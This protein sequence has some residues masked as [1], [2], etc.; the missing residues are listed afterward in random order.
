MVRF[1]GNLESLI[2]VVQVIGASTTFL[3]ALLFIWLCSVPRISPG[4]RW[5]TVGLIVS[6]LGFSIFTLP[7][8][9]I[10][11]ID[12]SGHL[13]F[14]TESL[15]AVC[16][17]IGTRQ[18]AGL[19]VHKSFYMYAL[20]ATMITALAFDFVFA[21]FLGYFAVIS[22]FNGA[23]IMATGYCIFKLH[24]EQWGYA[25][26]AIGILFIIWG[27]HW[28][29]A[30]VLMQ[31]EALFDYGFLFALLISNL[32]I[33]GY[34]AL[35]LHSLVERI[36]SAERV[37]IELSLKDGLTT[38]WNRRYLDNVFTNFSTNAERHHHKMALIYIDLDHFKPV[39]D[40]YGHDVGDEVLRQV[41]KR[42]MEISRSSDVAIRTGG[43]EFV[44]LIP[45]LDE[46]E[47]VMPQAARLRE[48]ITMPYHINGDTVTVG[49]S[50]GVSIF[51]DH[52]MELDPLLEKADKA[53]YHAKN[54][55]RNGEVMFDKTANT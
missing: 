8:I 10:G 25:Y 41:A 55:G 19:A 27:I 36:I 32:A 13:Y 30:P 24:K 40:T 18:F 47:N 12:L 4:I 1:G 48:R 20:A 15:F 39:N 33:L 5:W 26:K 29:D 53:M 42:I 16:M 21:S 54:S 3:D 51:P 28:L 11:D 6:L 2:E 43:D 23:L 44:V 35:M 14:L 52:A 7:H 22:I 46:D 9:M 49:A 37:A 34:A 17:L 38:L 50:I 45:H 31:F